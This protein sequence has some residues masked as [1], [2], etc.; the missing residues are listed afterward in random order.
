CALLAL[1]PRFSQRAGTGL[2]TQGEQARMELVDGS[3]IVALPHTQLRV[4]QDNETGTRIVLD[5]GSARFS[6]RHR[7]GLP[8]EVVSGNVSVRVVGTRFLVAA[9]DGNVSVEVFEGSV[10]VGADAATELLEEGAR[11]SN[12]AAEVSPLAANPAN[13]A[14]P[15]ATSTAPELFPGTLGSEPDP[16]PQGTQ[17]PADAPETRRGPRPT[18]ALLFAQAA[19]A[20]R[21]G[22]QSEAA[23]AYESLLRFHP[24]DE[25]APITAFELGRLRMDHLGDL[26]G[27]QSAFQRALQLGLGPGFREDCMARRVEALH[28][29]GRVSQCEDARSAY[30]TRFPRGRYASHLASLCVTGE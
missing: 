30:A 1:W 4:A 29:L 19:E 16:L 2:S 6:I 27:A 23:E 10:Q 14:N 8:F 3:Q 13:P 26:A 22:D 24:R 18:A 15:A 28:A 11:W 20:R 7:Q 21:N 12:A 5:H 9:D 17:E 25:R